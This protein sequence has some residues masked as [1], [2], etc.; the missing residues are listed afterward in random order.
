MRKWICNIKKWIS[1][2]RKYR[3]LSTMACHIRACLVDYRN[4]FLFTTMK[5]QNANQLPLNINLVLRTKNATHS[6]SKNS[7]TKPVKNMRNI[8]Y[9]NLWM[10]M[11]QYIFSRDANQ[12][13]SPNQ[14]AVLR[15]PTSEIHENP[16]RCTAVVKQFAYNTY[17][18][19]YLV[20]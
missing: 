13:W 1:Y 19:V 5:Y 8:F 16:T 2:I 3:F 12:Q 15:V 9:N 14:M 20:N 6:K 18:I 10:S 7:P 17:K 11:Y 4:P